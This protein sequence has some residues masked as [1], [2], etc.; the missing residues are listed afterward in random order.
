M[1]TQNVHIRKLNV[2]HT[3]NL[4][5]K[6]KSR[7]D[8]NSKAS[9]RQF[10]GDHARIQVQGKVI[11]N[12]IERVKNNPISS[13][14][15]SR[16]HEHNVAKQTDRQNCKRVNSQSCNDAVINMNEI[17]KPSQPPKL[18]N[19][20]AKDTEGDYEIFSIKSRG[21]SKPYSPKATTSKLVQ[22]SSSK[23]KHRKESK[24]KQIE[25]LKSQL[26]AIVSQKDK[27]KKEIYIITGSHAPFKLDSSSNEDANNYLPLEYKSE[28]H[29]P[30]SKLRKDSETQNVNRLDGKKPQEEVNVLSML[31]RGDLESRGVSS[32]GVACISTAS[33]TRRRKIPLTSSEYINLS[34]P[35]RKEKDFPKVISTKLRSKEHRC[36]RSDSA[37]GEKQ[38]CVDESG[39]KH[40]RAK[41]RESRRI[42]GVLSGNEVYKKRNRMLDDIETAYLKHKHVLPKE[43]AEA[44]ERNIQKWKAMNAEIYKSSEQHSHVL[45]LEKVLRKNRTNEENTKSPHAINK[46]NDLILMNAIVTG[47]SDV[48]CKKDTMHINKIPKFVRL[49]GIQEQAVAT[50]SASNNGE[51]QHL[52]IPNDVVCVC[53]DQ[54]MRLEVSF[55]HLNVKPVVKVRSSL[56]SQLNSPNT[57]LPASR[58]PIDNFIADSE[59]KCLRPNQQISLV[60]G[61]LSFNVDGVEPPKKQKSRIPSAYV[62]KK[63]IFS[64]FKK[65]ESVTLPIM[66]VRNINAPDCN[67]PLKSSSKPCRSSRTQT[68]KKESQK[69]R[70]SSK[71]SA[72][73]SESTLQLTHI[74]DEHADTSCAPESRNQDELRHLFKSDQDAIAALKYLPPKRREVQDPPKARRSRKL[75]KTV[76]SVFEIKPTQLVSSVISVGGNERASKETELLFKSSDGEASSSNMRGEISKLSLSDS[77]QSNGKVRKGNEGINAGV[78]SPMGKSQNTGKMKR[79]RPATSRENAKER[80]ISCPSEMWGSKRPLSLS[81]VSTSSGVSL[82]S[83]N[84]H[85]ETNGPMAAEHITL[86]V[87]ITSTALTKITEE[88][89]SQD[90]FESSD[91]SIAATKSAGGKIQKRNCG[92]ICSELNVS[93]RE[94]GK[95]KS[96]D[97]SPPSTSHSNQPLTAIDGRDNKKPKGTGVPI[98]TNVA[99]NKAKYSM[100]E[101]R[102]LQDEEIRRLTET[103]KNSILNE[104]QAMNMANMNNLMQLILKTKSSNS[105]SGSSLKLAQSTTSE[106][107][108][109]GNRNVIREGKKPQCEIKNPFN[110]HQ[111]VV[112]VHSCSTTQE[113][114][115]INTKRVPS[116]VSLGNTSTRYQR[117]CSKIP[118]SIR[119]PINR[120]GSAVRSPR[121]S[122]NERLCSKS[123]T[124]DTKTSL[125]SGFKETSTAKLAKD[126][127]SLSKFEKRKLYDDALR[128]KCAKPK[129]DDVPV[130]IFHHQG[131]NS[132][133]NLS[134]SPENMDK[135]DGDLRFDHQAQ[136]QPQKRAEDYENV[137]PSISKQSSQPQVPLEVTEVTKS[138]ERENI[139]QTFTVM[140]SHPNL[141]EVFKEKLEKSS[142]SGS[143]PIVGKESFHYPLKKVESLFHYNRRKTKIDDWENSLDINS[144]L[145]KLSRDLLD[146][147][148]YKPLDCILPNNNLCN[149]YSQSA[150]SIESSKNKCYRSRNNAAYTKCNGRERSTGI[151]RNDFTI[152]FPTKLEK[153]QRGNYLIFKIDQNLQ[154]RAA[155]ATSESYKMFMNNRDTSNTGASLIVR[156]KESFLVKAAP[157][158]ES[159]Y[160][161]VNDKEDRH[162][163]SASDIQ[164]K[165]S[166][167]TILSATNNRVD[168]HR[169][170]DKFPGK[171]I[172]FDEKS[173]QTDCK[174]R[175]KSER[176]QRKI[177]RYIQ[178]SYT[179]KDL[180]LSD[181][182][183]H[184]SVAD[185]VEQRVSED[186]IRPIIEKSLH[187]FLS[188]MEVRKGLRPDT[189]KCCETDS[190]QI[191]NAPSISDSITP[192]PTNKVIQ[193]VTSKSDTL[194][195][196]AKLS[197]AIESVLISKSPIRVFL[198]LTETNHDFKVLEKDQAEGCEVEKED[199]NKRLE[200]GKQSCHRLGGLDPSERASLDMFGKVLQLYEKQEQMVEDFFTSVDL[201]PS[202]FDSADGSSTSL[203]RHKSRS[204][205]LSVLKSKMSRVFKIREKQNNVSRVLTATGDGIKEVENYSVSIRKPLSELCTAAGNCSDEEFES[206]LP[207]IIANAKAWIEQVN[208][209]HGI[210]AQLL[211][212]KHALKTT[213]YFV[214]LLE[215]VANNRVTSLIQLHALLKM[216][217]SVEVGSI[218][219][220]EQRGR[221]QKRF[222]SIHHTAETEAKLQEKVLGNKALMLLK[223]LAIKFEAV[224]EHHAIKISRCIGRGL[225]ANELGLEAAMA[226]FA[227]M[228]IFKDFQN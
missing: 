18:H 164:S 204:S 92:E 124:S 87:E 133:S 157:L 166:V 108:T 109:N 140:A 180:I 121:I 187:D 107:Q 26:Q 111:Q 33:Q 17:S 51:G 170:I 112:I 70:K 8:E 130:A 3:D 213:Q 25:E 74:L 150:S 72:S 209:V 97:I 36:K 35:R 188:R 199:R 103:V 142:F 129:K 55:S 203:S 208:S 99:E 73:S 41:H 128:L 173:S 56:E 220:S 200:T 1:T 179:L 176:E 216:L 80:R 117:S 98:L 158:S 50:G 20:N 82:N 228:H 69:V 44:L 163:S 23:L 189:L 178:S 53:P 192:D 165:P 49:E 217:E 16:D 148:K 207:S 119:N 84:D 60:S 197:P 196:P 120:S 147:R 38:R 65:L 34:E 6:L 135:N 167:S 27:G 222:G 214:P 131:V 195:D 14:L 114:N 156:S 190:L 39:R 86:P 123:V 52:I 63:N 42:L 160:G 47:M 144:S 182:S 185:F 78:R 67:N 48:N 2:V 24:S 110:A 21:H 146:A 95:Y 162:T 186:H 136:M 61:G 159:G 215:A 181:S 104:I 201:V 206:Q 202:Q 219:D 93:G 118:K 141:T 194:S 19:P 183:F 171:E 226:Y 223:I 9:D 126:G 59:L 149:M 66:E 76:V 79:D 83:E 184:A 122:N 5:N 40:K 85:L 116:A 105:R 155:S 168:H 224:E 68:R 211:Q 169:D 101:A 198:N 96:K 30:N 31:N 127:K 134:I 64:G 115:L 154:K 143:R 205:I 29:D 227:K 94:K 11:E 106:R 100:S 22:T 218:P 37:I 172:H 139:Y 10:A 54:E 45:D 132:V 175:D 138:D 89:V 32:G 191:I 77:F 151:Q 62:S 193:P 71:S 81:G 13:R 161:S 90:T 4:K 221:L 43:A 91:L 210:L 28:G 15:A 153:K 102:S 88:T 177:L 58:S 225:I 7:A 57:L 145:K 152:Q 212:C 137:K 174:H 46:P 113:S 125:T 75:R 12:I